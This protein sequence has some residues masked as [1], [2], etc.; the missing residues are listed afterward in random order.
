MNS[1][2]QL[3]AEA[4]EVVSSLQDLGMSKAAIDRLAGA[5][6]N[7]SFFVSSNKPGSVSVKSLRGIVKTPQLVRKGLRGL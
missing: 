3:F 7:A 5:S 1:K 6:T 4:Q 2:Q